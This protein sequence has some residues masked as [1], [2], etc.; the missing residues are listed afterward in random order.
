MLFSDGKR[1]AGFTLIELLVVMALIGIIASIALPQFK[2]TT[3][4]AREVVL[5]ENL[6]QMRRVIDQFYVDKKR[7]PRSLQELVDEGYLRSI[8]EDPI[9]RSKE[10][11]VVVREEPNEGEYI[12]EEERG[13]ID[14]KSGS[15][16]ISSEGTP[17]SSW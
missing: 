14:V 11:W 8:P 7:Y 6:Y 13:I 9:T 2:G 10:T 12:P 3:K 16:M 4:R 5:K 1:H 17:Y 15:E